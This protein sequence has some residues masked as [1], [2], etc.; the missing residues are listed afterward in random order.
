MNTRTEAIEYLK[1]LGFYACERILSRERAVF[2]GAQPIISQSGMVAFKKGVYICPINYLWTILDMEPQ[3]CAS[4]RQPMSL[5]EACDAA[6]L[7]LGYKF[8]S[9]R[10]VPIT[11]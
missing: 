1:R 8:T 2:V 3:F 9:H 11:A 5:R 4:V 7:Q 10:Y 6:A